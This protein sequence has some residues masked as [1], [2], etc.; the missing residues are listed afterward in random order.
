[1]IATYGGQG[2]AGILAAIST[3]FRCLDA[4]DWATM[5]EIWH[6]DGEM[7]AVGA[8]PRTGID[9][10]TD[11]MEK[12]FV[13]WVEHRDQPGRIL[14]AGQTATVEVTFR[15][16]TETGAEVR[17]DAVDVIDFS[18]A[19]IVRLTNWYDVDLARQALAE[20]AGGA[21]K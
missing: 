21:T 14:V 6:P 20:A 16:T 13:P 1:M 7:R 3:Y 5:R 19:R 18:D 11:L 8:R 17:F 10:I 12:L 15:G 2:D 4:E 9:A